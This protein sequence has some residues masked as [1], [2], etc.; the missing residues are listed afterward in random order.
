MKVSDNIIVNS[1]QAKPATKMAQIRDVLGIVV[2]DNLSHAENVLMVEGKDDKLV[3]DK[4]LPNMSD[5]VRKAM[6]NGSFAID[7]LY[8]AGN[9][10]SR[11]TFLKDWQFRYHFLFDNDT[12]GIQAASDLQNNDLASLRN[13][14]M[15][16]C[17]GSPEA[18]IEDCYNASVYKQAIMDTFGVSLDK[19][20]FHNSR[21]WSDRVM[22]CFYAD[23]KPWTD[24]IKNSV[25][26]VVASSLPENPDE[27][28]NPNKCSSIRALVSAINLMLTGITE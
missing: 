11:A 9:A 13:I 3:L 6:R 16:I 2:S 25:K 23:G 1:G 14:T 18:E 22:A 8:G 7:C 17:N 28:L 5:N 21:K 10:V 19:S 26:A 27:A 4:I 12:A 24:E 20:E 15:T